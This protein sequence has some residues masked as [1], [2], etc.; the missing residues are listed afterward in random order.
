MTKYGAI[1]T[2]LMY[3]VK[4]YKWTFEYLTKVNYYISRL[5]SGFVRVSQSKN[6]VS[7]FQI[8]CKFFSFTLTDS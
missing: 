6:A 1:A 2:L 4:V 5:N 8:T 3:R 7:A